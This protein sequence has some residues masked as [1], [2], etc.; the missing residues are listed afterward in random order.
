MMKSTKEV[1]GDAELGDSDGG[2][3][4]DA[5]EEDARDS[6]KKDKK[7]KTEKEVLKSVKKEVAKA[8]RKAEKSADKKS[9]KKADKKRKAGADSDEE[10]N[11][12]GENGK[13]EGKGSKKQK[14]SAFT[15]SEGL[16]GLLGLQSN[17]TRYQVRHIYFCCTVYSC[18]LCPW[19]PLTRSYTVDTCAARIFFVSCAEENIPFSHHRWCR[20]CGNTSAA[21]PC[22]TRQTSAR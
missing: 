3:D 9:D 5:A 6:K 1:S 4:H 2:D 13:K 22:R 18:A 14:A 19:S 10:E 8:D 11:G 7:L 15:I 21:T 17:D 12:N 16:C 20:K